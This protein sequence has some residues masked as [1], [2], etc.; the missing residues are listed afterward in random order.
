MD[1]PEGSEARLARARA[2]LTRAVNTRE[3]EHFV[4]KA[5]WNPPEE[6]L[7]PREVEVC[8]DADACATDMIVNKPDTGKS[9]QPI[10]LFG[11]ERDTQ[12]PNP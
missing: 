6:P 3:E 7:K 1:F 5:Q 12:V 8:M 9:E 4:L 11:T 2:L 10:A